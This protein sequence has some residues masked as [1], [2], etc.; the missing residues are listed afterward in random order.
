MS[1]LLKEMKAYNPSE[2]TIRANPKINVMGMLF[3][4]VTIELG[5]HK[6]KI[7]EE[8]DGPFSI[9]ESMQE[10]RLLYLSLSPLQVHAEETERTAEDGG[11]G[12]PELNSERYALQ[13]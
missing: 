5:N 7:D 13:G 11:E 12:A 9:I 3:E 4:G 1:I 8:K 2:N 6:E 10:D